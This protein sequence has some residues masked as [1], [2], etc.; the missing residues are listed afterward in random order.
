M[1]TNERSYLKKQQLQAT[2]MRGKAQTYHKQTGRLFC[3]P[4][5]RRANITQV[6]PR[7]CLPFCYRE[8]TSTSVGLFFF[9]CTFPGG[10]LPSVWW[11][12]AR[13]TTSLVDIK[14]TGLASM[15]C[16]WRGCNPEELA[17]PACWDGVGFNVTLLAAPPHLGASPP[18]NPRC[19]CCFLACSSCMRFMRSLKA[20][21]MSCPL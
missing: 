19:A 10:A 11:T 6:I 13:K 18:R 14:L 16:A 7:A 2:Q 4:R 9:K 3:S 17:S 8:T 1:Q 21:G 5:K 15:P 12:A 20:V